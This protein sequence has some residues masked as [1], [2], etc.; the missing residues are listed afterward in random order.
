MKVLGPHHLMCCWGNLL[1]VTSEIRPPDIL[2]QHWAD[3]FGT[4][5]VPNWQAF[6]ARHRYTTIFPLEG[7]SSQQ[8]E[9]DPEVNY[10][11]HSKEAIGHIPCPQAEIL[12]EM[13]P[14]CVVKLS[15]G[16]AGLGN[17]FVLSRQDKITTQNYIDTHWPESQ[18]ITNTI[19]DDV[20]R[21]F[22]IQFYL[23]KS[24]KIH[25]LGFT[26]QKFDSN[27]KW[28]GATF[29]SKEQDIFYAEFQKIVEPVADYLHEHSYFGLVGIDVLRCRNNKQ[30]LIDLNPRL[31]GVTPFLLASRQLL[32]QGHS[33]GIYATS[34]K[35]DGSTENLI[36]AAKSS[37]S[38]TVIIYSVIE[39]KP[40]VTQCHAS[41]HANSQSDCEKALIQIGLQGSNSIFQ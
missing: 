23:S 29:S 41:A 37:D 19:I 25:W 17:F 36:L 10:L 6:D 38:A 22:G 31:T 1:P 5:A 27:L 24:C 15:H 26:N 11:L 13:K 28:A 14:P 30:Y 12:D 32:N 34:L 2:F 4:E 40:G 9:I 18:T 3:R 21:D 20:S 33:E 16:Y 35:F 8:Q 39:E 7:L